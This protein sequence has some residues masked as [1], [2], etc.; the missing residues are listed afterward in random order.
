MNKE[1]L[2]KQFKEAIKLNK[3]KFDEVYLNQLKLE[4]VSMVEKPNG[5]HE[6]KYKIHNFNFNEIDE[7]ETG[8]KLE[9][10]GTSLYMSIFLDTDLM[11]KDPEVARLI[12]L[13]EEEAE[14]IAEKW[15][16]K[17]RPLFYKIFPF[18]ESELAYMGL[19]HRIWYEQ[20]RIL[21]D[22]YDIDWKTPQD[23]IPG[24]KFD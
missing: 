9:N 23:R 14:E 21:K 8:G 11:R 20:K 2:Q 12:D 19:C 16:K 24:A 5:Y 1:D 18:L 17:N 22:R 13:A 6:V 3:Y 15:R 4:I 7:N 10:F